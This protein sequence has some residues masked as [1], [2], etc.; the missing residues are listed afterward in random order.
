M[1]RRDPNP[2][3]LERWLDAIEPNS[4][5]ARDA[6]HMRRI[7]A[8]AAALQD[9]EDELH[10]A[11]AAARDAGDTWDMIGVALGVTRQAAFQRFGQKQPSVR[12]RPSRKVPARKV[13]RKSIRPTR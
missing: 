4:A 1:T 5:D 6:I 2:D 11:V 10:S 12:K 9:A 8:A 3:E 13:V 7:I